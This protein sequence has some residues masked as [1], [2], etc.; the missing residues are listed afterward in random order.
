M[1]IRIKIIRHQ[2][3]LSLEQLAEATS[4]TKSY[5]SKVERGLSNPS[6]SASLKLA[7]AL[8]VD[9]TDLFESPLQDDLVCLI[10]KG[11]GLHIAAPSVSERSIDVLADSMTDKQMQ[12]FILTPACEFSD[13]PLM[14]SHAGDEYLNVLSGEIEVKFPDRIECLRQG[15]SLYFKAGVPHQIRRLTDESTSVLVVVAQ[16]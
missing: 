13:G 1:S 15:D 5:L 7:A 14:H 3:G 12:P 4:L 6:I 8:N 10:K 16:C 9:V 2:L 11:E